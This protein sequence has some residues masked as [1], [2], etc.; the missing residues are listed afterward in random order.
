MIYDIIL[1]TLVIRLDNRLRERRLERRLSG[2]VQPERM[3]S[4][5]AY[6]QSNRTQ[7]SCPPGS[8]KAGAHP[9]REIWAGPKHIETL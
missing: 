9:E 7:A 8:L 5:R 3:S 6:G 1:K 4:S 2:P